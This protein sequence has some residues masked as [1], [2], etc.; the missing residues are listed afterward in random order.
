MKKIIQSFIEFISFVMVIVV[1]WILIRYPAYTI[2]IYPCFGA[3]II[4]FHLCEDLF[5]EFVVL[6][7]SIFVGL[8]VII[9]L[10]KEINNFY[11][12]VLLGE[13]I[14][15][16]L[17]YSLLFKLDAYLQKQQG[18]WTEKKEF[19]EKEI[20]R[21]TH[22][23]NLLKDATFNNMIKIQN[24][25]F[26]EEVINKLV[27]FQACS[28]LC[29]YVSEV[30]IRL[31]PRCKSRLYITGDSSDNFIEKLLAYY[32]KNVIYIPEVSTYAK[33]YDPMVQ[34]VV[35]SLEQGNVKSIVSV[36][37]DN[38]KNGNIEGHLV[39]YSTEYLISED[40]LRLIL[41]LSS[42][43]NIAITNL[44]T[45]E[46]VKQLSISDTLTGLFVQRYFKELLTE[47]IR[48]A[49]YYGKSLVL[50]IFDIDNFKQ[51]ND[52]YGHNIGDEVLVRFA[53]I[54]RARL[55]ETDI[56][57]RYGGDEFATVLLNV[58]LDEARNICEE[59]RSTVLKETLVLSKP[60]D[61]SSRARVKF[62]ISCGISLYST[63]FS[64]TEEFIDYVDKLLYK[65]KQT[66]KNRVIAEV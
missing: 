15:V 1:I 57:A 10:P 5:L 52:T 11:R 56:I 46:Y 36:R 49:R 18:L 48:I 39:V 51:I 21:L 58:D 19:L 43:I 16:L 41:L 37:L 28:Q 25:K 47:Q 26:I 42:Y 2:Y 59:I 45:F 30:L 14:M 3:C 35:S 17:W 40:D 54:L 32:D 24:Y 38:P 64:T 66:G 23:I 22:E 4:V 33:N 31:L 60:T 12:L 13:I 7:V 62:E 61:F 34:L 50:A 29:E 65:A 20:G 63:R 9:L 53:N 44:K 6:F 55:R 8:I 27:S